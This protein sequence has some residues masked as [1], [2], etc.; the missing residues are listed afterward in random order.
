MSKLKLKTDPDPDF[1]KD[2]EGQ[3]TD[4]IFKTVNEKASVAYGYITKVASVGGKVL[5][6]GVTSA[7]LVILPYAITVSTE[8]SLQQIDKLEGARLGYDKPI[9]STFG[10]GYPPLFD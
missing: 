2:P 6:V 10:T 3:T 1:N 7:A 5:W 4:S 8:M 9:D